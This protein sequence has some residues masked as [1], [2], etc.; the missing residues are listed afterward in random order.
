M[1][2]GRPV[3]KVRRSRSLLVRLVA[4]FLLLSIVMVGIVAALAA[5]RARGSLENSVYGRL[6]AAQELTG[7]SVARWIAEERRNVT[8]AAGLLGG[9]EQGGVLSGEQQAV[10]DLLGVGTSAAARAKARSDVRQ[11]LQYVVHQSSDAQEMFV[12]DD[13]GRIVASTTP[14]HEGLDQSA[15]A[16]AANSRSRQYVQ[17]VGRSSLSGGPTIIIGT[18]LFD[19]YGQQRGILAANMDLSRVDKIVLEKTG[20]GE[21]GQTY[22]VDDAR[23]FVAAKVGQKS[24]GLRSDAIDAALAHHAGEAQYVN[25][26][27]VPVIGAYTWVDDLGTALVSEIPQDVAFRPATQLAAS[28][29]LIGLLVVL[30]MAGL[31][32]WAARRIA[33]PILAI[34]ETAVAVRAGDLSREAPVTTQDEVGILAETFNDMT[35]QLR[36][37]VETLERRVDERTAELAEQKAY[38][39]ALVEISPAAVVTMDLQQRVTGW[40]PAATRLFGYAPDEALGRVIDDLVMADPDMRA[41]AVAFART[42]VE[43]GRVDRITRR[44]RKDGELVDVEIV[45]V[46]LVVEGAQIGSYAVYH[47]ITELQEARQEADRANDA[48]SAFLATM[49]HEIRTPMNAI[50]GMSGLLTDTSLDDEQREYVEII[51]SSGDSLLAIINDIL[52]FSKIEAGHMTIE[53]EEFSLRSCLEASLDVI[54][55]LAAH[56]HLSLAYEMTAR[57]PETVVGDVLRLR[58]ILLNLLSNAV[59]FTEHGHVRVAVDAAPATDGPGATLLLSVTDTGIGLTPEQAGRLFRSFSQA[60][61]S[62]ARRYGGTGLGLAISKQLATLMGGDLRVESPGLDAAGS[63]FHLTIEVVPL[64]RGPASLEASAGALAG[65]RVLLLDTDPMHRRVLGDLLHGWAIDVVEADACDGAVAALDRAAADADPFDVVV[66]GVERDSAGDGAALARARVGTPLPPLV[67]TSSLPRREALA[68]ID[69]WDAAVGWAA[70]P[71][72]PRALLVALMRVLGVDVPADLAILGSERVDPSHE[73]H[74]SLRVL[75][76]EDNAFNQKL[77][78][79]LVRRL[80]HE[81]DVVEN[82]AEAVQAATATAY[83]VVLM[84]LQM[85][86]MDGF[87]ATRRIITALGELRPPIIAL[88]A[89][90]L[91][92]DRDACIAAGMVGFL[93]KPIRREELAAALAGVAATEP[94]GVAASTVPVAVLRSDA[95]PVDLVAVSARPAADRGSFQ[96]RVTSMVGLRDEEFERELVEE[97]LTGAVVLRG[98][99]ETAWASRDW[100]LLRRAAHTLKAQAAMFGATGLVEVCRAVESAAV[101]GVSDDVVGALVAATLQE[102]DRTRAAVQ[103]F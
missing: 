29:G 70:K 83:D 77:A 3:A 68:L 23:E 10:A 82:G 100:A 86:E 55:P 50:I 103:E 24:T 81:V 54:A 37:N 99:I 75:L 20:L 8:F 41:E 85:P 12:L 33:N 101:D 17:P 66:V 51:G 4:T 46:P 65:R 21:G 91:S 30:L 56:K 45:V 84:D 2:E 88:T 80:G 6:N 59:K 9:D 53:A 63:T 35:S 87:E 62:T 58:Q 44:M 43:T 49:S 60:D 93:T 74:R 94:G 5:Q 27:G 52:D 73:Q 15:E 39:E 72:K 25:Y 47:D 67:V 57:T 71:M 31:I 79:T 90:A 22:L 36:T 19:N 34:T 61:V 18:P 28:I 89:N 69:G 16:Y 7:D 78:V 14:T 48:K 64:S 92:E 98:D 97:F 40:N 13:N 1:S 26:M 42:A 11:I 38:F 95:A 76:A 96:E 32:Y 102:S